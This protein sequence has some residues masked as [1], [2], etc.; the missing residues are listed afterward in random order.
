M[1][2]NFSKS[3]YIIA[4]IAVLFA[5]SVIVFMLISSFK[6][7]DDKKTE[8]SD[9]LQPLKAQL[10]SDVITKEPN[11][12][13][14]YVNSDYF[15][16][17]YSSDNVDIYI[18]KDLSAN[19][20]NKGIWFKKSDNEWF[21]YSFDKINSINGQ[22]NNIK[23]I[24]STQGDIIISPIN[25]QDGYIG[26]SQGGYIAGTFTVKDN[27]YYIIS[28]YIDGVINCAYM[29]VD[30]SKIDEGNNLIKENALTMILPSEYFNGTGDEDSEVVDIDSDPFAEEFMKGAKYC[31]FYAKKSYKKMR[32]I[33]T[34]E[35]FKEIQKIYIRRHYENKDDDIC[36]AAENE[37]HAEDEVVFVIDN[38][39]ENDKFDFVMFSDGYP[40][41]VRATAVEYEES[42]HVKRKTSDAE[43]ATA[44]E[45]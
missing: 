7:N 33:F 17:K 12:D 44:S 40:G 10:V 1:R 32:L 5:V 4:G 41:K 28:Y 16:T 27:P 18:P 15:S 21:L 20:T 19:E 6:K 42:S 13:I 31:E 2:R 14:N 3:D 24:L 9:P 22:N 11:T 34:C 35:N 26:I 23:Q 25:R 8:Q 43:T 39:N 30:L 37:E 38:V 29:T 36:Y 45:K